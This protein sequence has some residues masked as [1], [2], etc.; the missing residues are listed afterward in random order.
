M[1]KAILLGNTSIRF[2]VALS[3]LFGALIFLIVSTIGTFAGHLKIGFVF[4][5]FA[6]IYGGATF[7]NYG[8]DKID[9]RN[10]GVLMWFGNLLEGAEYEV[11]AGD[12]WLFRFFNAVGVDTYSTMQD[13]ILLD[14]IQ[15]ETKNDI[16]LPIWLA[17]QFTPQEGSLY[18]YGNLT[19]MKGALTTVAKAAARS[20]AVTCVSLN[21]LLDN[22]DKLEKAVTD[23]LRMVS[24][25]TSETDPWGVN[26]QLVKLADY[27][28]PKNITDAAAE[29]EEAVKKAEAAK[30][31]LDIVIG[32]IDALKKAG[33]DPNIASVQ[34]SS[35]GL[36]ESGQVTGNVI[37]GLEASA[38]ALGQ[39]FG[40]GL[41][42]RK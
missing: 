33:V 40:A 12:I 7:F 41:A 42:S 4:A 5:T 29:T 39:G 8:L 15:V 16:T 19:D 14:K 24:R 35:I 27:E 20:H 37:A 10:R 31:R 36:Q 25:G 3:V 18:W 26:I 23:A 30:R 9:I 17:V 21:E 22:A 13:P 1:F 38:R 28:P 6:A 32:A 34:A 11:P 2:G